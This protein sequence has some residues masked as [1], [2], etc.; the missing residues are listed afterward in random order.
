MA[1]HE[2]A[3][4][5]RLR[6]KPEWKRWGPYLVERAWGNVRE[7]D[8]PG[9]DAWNDFP[10]EHARSR[11][12]RWTE[13]GLAG[14]CDG[15]QQLCLSLALWNERDAILKERLF[16][17]SNGEGNHGE[18]IKEHYFY[19]DGL[20]THA[21]QKALYQ[22]PQVAFP[23]E[24]LRAQNARRG[25]EDDEYELAEAL[26]GLLHAGHYFDVFIEYAKADRE[27]ILMRLTAINRGPDAAPLHVLP[28]LW[29][30]NTWA[31]NEATPRPRLSRVDPTTVRV[32][33]ETM[34]ER[35]WFV[36]PGA[37]YQGLLFTEN[38]TNSE[39]LFGQP[40]TTPYTKDGIDLAVVQGMRERV[41]PEQT[42]TKCAAH[43]VTTV[44]PGESVTI[45]TRLADRRLT[46]PFANVD[47]LFERRIDETNDFY[48]AVQRP[49]LTD[50]ERLV[51][52]QAFAGLTWSKAFY[53]YDVGRWL[54]SAVRADGHDGNDGELKN[55]E[56]AH[57]RADDVVSVPDKWEYPWFAAWDLI[58]QTVTIALI[59]PTFAKQQIG[60]LLNERYMHP[61]GQ[62]A[63]FEGNFS[64]VHPPLW[65][66]GALHV[67][68]SDRLMH[69][70]PDTAFLERIFHQ[71]LYN[72]PW[73]F[74]PKGLGEQSALKGGFLG[75]D[76]ISV[77]D[78]NEPPAGT[79]LDQVDSTGWLAFYCLN[80]LEIAV[81]LAQT[82]P[83][84]EDA[85]LQ[86][87]YTFVYVAR[88]L[89][90][91]QAGESLFWH[92]DDGFF[93]DR[94]HNAGGGSIP[95]RIRSYV[96]LMP[97][98]AIALLDCAM[99]EKLKRLRACIHELEARHPAWFRRVTWQQNGTSIEGMAISALD[100]DHLLRLLGHITDASAMLSD[101]GLRSVS[102][103]HAEHPYVLVRNAETLMLKYEPGEG[104][105]NVSGG[106]SNWRGPIWAPMNHLV[107]EA[108]RKHRRSL[109]WDETVE[110]PAGSGNMAN[111]SAMAD[112][113]CRRLVRIFLK[114]D[115]GARPVF[116][117]APYLQSHPLLK[118][119]VLFYEYFHG[120]HGY[121][122]GASHQ[123]GWTALVARLIQDGGDV[124]QFFER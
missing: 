34:G 26:A 70:K 80:L 44:A 89:W 32:E 48:I 38:E 46:R 29:F 24:T 99:L 68:H 15:E 74:N 61:D 41:N 119:V 94:L 88:H 93:Y 97:L 112:D 71:M 4:H 21:Y 53:H 6:A 35:W 50:D 2:S 77:F 58:F 49:D 39:A 102:K 5:R 60:L 22:Y 3:E 105:S 95:L 83:V 85:A 123:N 108:L 82:K 96:G 33:H 25:L 56:W 23:Y 43:F 67:Y 91:E 72:V 57:L 10:F 122:L 90:E 63:A 28:Q 65:A 11:A 31:W 116:G 73:W 52:R 98:M 86:L 109:G 118:D 84:Y 40:N 69:G 113:L 9:D 45:C 75:M 47:A 1:K 12:Y 103:Y 7:S 110:Y 79:F 16:G 62:I 14:F 37:G 106:N 101:Y 100:R 117:N 78:R 19:L 18:D 121:G 104:R 81:E 115:A 66:W 54:Q 36:R 107:I 114:D 87:V 17:L 120:D 55:R 76:N 92:E 124:G 42:G 59:D 27:D 20:P 13:D 64:M 8:P 30:R 51:Q 111:F